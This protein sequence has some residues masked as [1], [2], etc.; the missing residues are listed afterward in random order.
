MSAAKNTVAV[1]LN[2]GDT[3]T[4]EYDAD[5]DSSSILSGYTVTLEKKAPAVFPGSVGPGADQE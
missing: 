3:I 5:G 1:I 2:V 4:V